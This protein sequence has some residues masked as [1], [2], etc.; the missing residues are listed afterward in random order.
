[1]FRYTLHGTQ[2]VTTRGLV[3]NIGP[4]ENDH[5]ISTT[6]ILNPY[7]SKTELDETVA[8]ITKFCQQYNLTVEPYHP[9]H[10]KVTGSANSFNKAL[11]VNMQYF[12]KDS[13]KYYATTTPIQ[14]PIEWKDKVHNILGLDTQKIAIPRFNLFKQR[15]ITTTF[16]P[17]KLA[18]L[19]N[20][21]PNL[22]GTD[23]KIGVIELGGGYN[24]SDINTYF[25]LLGITTPP[26]ITPVSVDGATNSPGEYADYEVVLDIE[27]IAANV[28]GAD[29]FVYFAPNSDQGFYNAINTA[30]NQNCSI[31]SI[32]WGSP[33]TYWSTL[34]LSSYNNLFQYASTKNVTILAAAGDNGSSD[35]AEGENVDFPSSSPFVLACGGTRVVVSNDQSVITQETVWNN[36]SLTS[37]TGGGISRVFSK[38]SYQNNILFDLGIRRGVPDV[39]AN[40]DPNTGYIIYIYG[41]TVVIGGTSAVSPLWSGLLGRINQSL[42]HNVGFIQ[43][44]LYDNP[45]VCKDITEGN[46]GAFTASIGWDPCTGNGSPNGM[47]LLNLFASIMP[48]VAPVAAF[49]ASNTSGSA[50]LLVDFIDQSTNTPTY[51]SWNFGDGGL[52]N[53]KNPSHSYIDPGIYTV[54]LTA[55]NDVGSNTITI[56]NYITVTQRIIIPVAAFTGSPV[57][58]VKPLTA[59]FIDQST[60]S[61]TSWYWTFGDGTTSILQNP[62]HKYLTSGNYTVSLRATNSA[63]SNTITKINYIRVTSIANR[64][65]PIAGFYGFPANGPA[66]L[67]VYFTDQSNGIVTSRTWFFGDGDYSHDSNPTHIY[68]YPGNYTV[69]L[70]VRNGFGS[71]KKTKSFYVKVTN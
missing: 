55:T 56:T 17:T 7:L 10:L 9:Y 66:P 28:P 69:T 62:I 67:T 61:P 6:W 31:V 43:P 29:I 68:N 1:M 5:N 4:V 3:R 38:P 45:S 18:E 57:N 51:W 15:D 48:P 14:I 34:A 19:Y 60:N 25:T 36:N 24:I 50:T 40:A 44:I 52:S 35:G 20:Y 26:K 16:Y 12:D 59:T 46:N 71:N 58:G 70:M 49:I 2:H 22:D 63:G 54:S 23:V 33:E 39:S 64:K 41:G 65:P 21:P 47:E 11:I 27:I 37:A 53:L 42:G 13:H 32:S 30:I 8:D